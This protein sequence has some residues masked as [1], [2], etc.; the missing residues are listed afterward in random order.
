MPTLEVWPMNATTAVDSYWL[1]R[2]HCIDVHKQLYGPEAS[3]F[4]L[5]DVM[6]EQLYLHGASI[7]D[8]QRTMT[9]RSEKHLTMWLIKWGSK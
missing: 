9:F 8:N 6:K 5:R 3:A 7:S 2:N 4:S 1:F